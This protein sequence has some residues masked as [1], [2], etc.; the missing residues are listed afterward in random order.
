MAGLVGDHLLGLHD[1]L[2]P[3]L[4]VVLHDLR[5]VVD[6]VQEHVVEFR[7]FRLDV[8]RHGE[9]DD[10][11]RRVLALLDHALEHALAEDRQR[12]RRARDDDVELRAGGREAR[13]A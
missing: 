4:Q 5:E 10:E 2:A 3:D 7:G 1:R 8:A 13:S 11:H 6:A 9:V 12:A